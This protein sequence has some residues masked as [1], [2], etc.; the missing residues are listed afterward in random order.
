MTPSRRPGSKSVP[1]RVPAPVQRG[2]HPESAVRGAW[3]RLDRSASP[4]VL[5]APFFV[6]FLVFGLFPLGYTLYVSFTDW[7]LLGGGVHEFIGFD[8]YVRL[9]GD[10]HFWNAL[11]NTLSIFVLSTVPQLAFA[12]GLA[13][14][15]NTRLRAKTAF[16]LGVLLPN[17][18]S[19]VAVTIVFAQIFDHDFGLLNGLLSIVG[20]GPVDWQ[21]GRGSSHVAIAV[22]VI[23]RW[24]GYNA[25]VYLAAMQ[26]IRRELYEAA[27]LDGAGN[28]RMFRSI[29][30]PS[31][32]P[33]IMFTVIVSTINGMQLF[34]EPL[35]FEGTPGRVTGG[36]DRQF[37]T[38]TLLVFEHG[39]RRFDFGY[40][41]TVSWVMFLVIALVAVVN[42]ALMRRIGGSR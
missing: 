35:L 25:I 32:R 31:L 7:H 33:V 1:L 36:A 9:F 5:V 14:L 15:L 4:Y 13:H 11:L 26:T 12:L 41:A 30:I 39:F 24:T 22:M 16:R 20:V 2:R 8:N 18:A 3:D 27:S 29:T 28:W 6:L 19:L 17:V 10:A 37:Q 38:L 23:W 34:A 21:A 40:A 42:F